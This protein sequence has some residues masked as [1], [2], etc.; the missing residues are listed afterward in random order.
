MNENDKLVIERL[1]QRSRT[2]NEQMIHDG[3]PYT[4]AELIA[5][6][7]KGTALGKEVVDEVINALWEEHMRNQRIKGWT[8]IE[9]KPRYLASS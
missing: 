9:K 1:I 4:A 3:I 8:G 2:S 7:K 6:I 5:E